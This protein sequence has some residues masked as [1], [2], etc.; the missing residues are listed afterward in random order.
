MA[1]ARLRLP[2]ARSRLA[3]LCRTPVSSAGSAG[4]GQ[5]QTPI[6]DALWK[7][8]QETKQRAAEQLHA[9]TPS[10][11]RRE[12][13]LVTKTPEESAASISY[14][15][16]KPGNAALTDRYINPWGLFRVGRLLEDLDALAGT[17]AFGHCSSGNPHDEDLHIVTASVDRIKYMHRPNVKDDIQLSGQVTFVGRSSMEI[18]MQARSSWS[19]S[20]FMESNFTFVARDPKTNKA[21]QINALQV[22]TPEEVARFELGRQRDAARKAKRSKSRKNILGRALD[23]DGIAAAFDLLRQGTTLCTMPT[24]AD[25]GEVLMQETK[26][27]NTLTAMPQHRNTAGRIFGGFL[28]RRAYELAH[29]T[30]YV[31]GG[32]RPVFM[33]L[34]EVIFRSPVSVG[35]LL[36]F[37]SSVLYTSEEVDPKGRATIHVEVVANV[38]VPERRQATT[39]NVFNFTFGLSD[40]G[41]DAIMGKDIELRRVVPQTLEEACRV[42][43]RYQADLE[44]V[45]EERVLQR[46]RG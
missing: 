35:D 22:T 10:D 32:K 26:L 16:S 11:P 45:E 38:L 1:L 40:Q 2:A 31:F 23:E 15:F 39:S 25:T 19:D 27:Q 42:I 3:P 5:H 6:V 29:A 20:P 13:T 28:M 12:R 14:D 17:I 34:D 44:Q 37:D 9:A 46:A 7:R 30:A 8:R 33:E 21:A 4:P 41:G 36:R 18:S 24:L 43:E